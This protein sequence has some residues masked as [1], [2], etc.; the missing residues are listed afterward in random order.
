MSKEVLIV[1]WMGIMGGLFAQG[2]FN[3][4]Q[5]EEDK[6]EIRCSLGFAVLVFLPVI[7][8]AG[9]RDGTGYA[10]TNGY[11]ALYKSLPGNMHQL[12]TYLGGFEKDRG[13]YFLAGTI[14]LIFG[15]SYRPFLMIISIIQG[16]SLI[17]FYQKYSEN[18][19]MSITLFILSGEYLGW[20]MNGMRQFLAVCI[21]YFAIPWIIKKKYIRCILIILL[22]STIHQT[23]IIMLP[24]I[25]IVQGKPW[26]KKTIGTLGI[27][28]VALFATSQFTNFLNATMEDTVYAANI[29]E[30]ANQ[31]GTSPIRV[32]VY[33]LPALLALLGKNYIKNDTLTN[34]S[35]NM[36]IITMSLSVIGMMTSGVMIGRLPIYTSLFNYVLLPYELES[37]FE[38][39]IARILKVV[40]I[41]MYLMYY[42]YL[43]HFAYGRF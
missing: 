21:I 9:F 40:M 31:T 20:M 5:F 35:V 13:F 37:I 6:E 34:I 43:M 17:K 22:A 4:V 42:Y 8:W 36:S 29:S 38:E 3:R 27:A 19:V 25:F 26:N 15:E 18:Y 7:L 30:M 2:Q 23:A 14:K 41:L 24:I 28:L 33:S 11:I 12:L 32:L 16:M 39:R 1:I 10:D